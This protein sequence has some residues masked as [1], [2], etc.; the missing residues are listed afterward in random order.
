LNY[1]NKFL[2]FKGEIVREENLLSHGYSTSKDYDKLFELIKTQRVVCFVTYKD[3]IG[4]DG[5]KLQDIC[6][7][8]V[9]PSDSMI[10]IGARGVSHI[11]AMAIRGRTLK[12]DF[13][14][15]CV[16]R[17]LEFIEPNTKLTISAD[18]KMARK[19]TLRSAYEQIQKADDRSICSH[20]N[21]HIA[22]YLEALDQM[23]I[24]TF[25]SYLRCKEL[26]NNLS[27]K[28]ENE[29]LGK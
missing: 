15:Q 11:T 19:E 5:H 1:R 29:L 8:S 18:S 4:K 24:I 10:D 21:S 23:E 6:Q 27:Y 22:G 25:K 12:E 2:N 7:S 26:F 14:R 3:D 13:I 16:D 28:R 9:Q 20:K 17:E